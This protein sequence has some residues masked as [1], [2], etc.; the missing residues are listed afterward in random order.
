MSGKQGFK[1]LPAYS[2][3][4][5]ESQVQEFWQRER[6]PQR[7]A[8]HRIGK[9]KFF[10]L[11]GPP[12]V[13]ALPHVGH[14]KTTTYKDVW[15]RLRY[16]QGSDAL[17]Q[18][19]FDCHGLPV[20]VI[21]EKE[22]GLQSKRDVLAK[23]IAAFDEAC[24]QK[25][26]DNEKHWLSY[27]KRL[28][29]WRGFSEPYFTYKK[30][31]IESAWWTF[32][33]LHD[34]GFVTRGLRSIHWCPHCETA[35]SGYEV[36]DSYKMVS[37]PSIVIKFKVKNTKN[38]YLLVWTTTPWTLAS[39]VAIAA[40]PKE[41]YVKAEVTIS[42]E[43]QVLIIGKARAKPVLE[44]LLGLEYKLVGELQGSDLDGVEYEPV[45]DSQSQHSLDS[46]KLARRVYLS[47]PI[48]VR[49]NYKK[50]VKSEE[51][52]GKDSSAK[53][54]GA[55]FEEFVTMAEGTGLVHC[56]PGHGLTDNHFGKHYNL[57]ALSPVDEAGKFT[58]DVA[59][60][61]G[62]F[63]KS[64]DKDII[65]YLDQR[66]ALAYSGKVT[67]S[68]PLCWRCKTPLV[69]RLSEQIYLSV[70]P[71]REQMLG[72]NDSCNWLPEFGR[73]A[74]GNWV[75]AATDW[76][77]SQQ[78]FWGI[79]IPL[80]KCGKCG[81]S[82]VVEG[83]AELEKAAGH[84]LDD[85]HRHSVDSIALPCKACGGSMTRVPDIFNVWFDSG[86]APWASLG[87]PYQNKQLFESVFPVDLINE[88]QDQVRG[89]FYV[90]SF[91]SHAVFNK[92]AFKSVGLMGWVVDE[93]GDKMSKSVGN[94]V[95]ATDGL[96]KLGSDA[97]RMYFC[98]EIAPWDVQKFSFNTAAE[99]VRSINIYWNTYKFYEMYAQGES[100][101]ASL[102]KL[103]AV[104]DKWIIS[105]LNSAEAAVNKHFDAFEFHLAG[106]AV[107]DF[108]V[109]DFSRW[110][111]K[112]IRDRVSVDAKG[113]DK[114]ACLAVM[115]HVLAESS[116][117]FAPVMPF[118]TEHVHAGVGGKDSVHFEDY[119]LGDAKVVDRELEESMAAVMALT[120]AAN[121]IR[122]AANV[123]LRWPLEEMV[124]VCDA[125]VEP[126]VKP[127]QSILLGQ[128]NVLAVKFASAA[129]KTKGYASQECVVGSKPA[130]VFLKVE[131]S[132]EVEREGMYRELIRSVQASRKKSGFI[133]Q[134]KIALTVSTE[135][136]QFA[137]LLESRATALAGEVGAASVKVGSLAGEFTVECPEAKA[138][139][140]YA[141]Q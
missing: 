48:M 136:K 18:P 36:S 22:L 13:N 97:L 21:V 92:P 130:T 8:E 127:L 86:I 62:K 14:V 11:D 30:Y 15:T 56:A 94:V 128:N 47:I 111:V 90:L 96:D 117:L 60:W 37:D 33:Q 51:S 91:L 70:E 106:R 81:A 93:K 24:F 5:I 45:I 31:Y 110:Y 73:E 74:F 129:P 3:K 95:S 44:E 6:V 25:I 39:N 131:R 79:P 139:A 27:Y 10:L 123:K 32:K 23:G 41:K 124:V 119:P 138:T 98:W 54:S 72:D 4:E 103:T 42:G 29:A 67:H 118:I 26:A 122:Q 78:R 28:G 105:R 120:E 140:K 101:P 17:I 38:E 43:K 141:R 58:A 113:S 66:G 71:I 135:D 50:H 55:E 76:C 68:Y 46:S 69:F 100:I 126:G 49:K 132:P 112:L 52:G 133:V 108:I 102:P 82:H 77:I 99:V 59:E 115:R 84:K 12:Y 2:V 125:S 88:S 89:W 64:A 57:P 83:A 65:E 137:K 107:M 63:V 9:K 114:A 35:L 109:N 85:L 80:W 40:A 87:Y 7:L 16:M 75:A 104:E 53:P 121:S 20:E 19:G 134:E 61:Q 34:K 116:K 1:P